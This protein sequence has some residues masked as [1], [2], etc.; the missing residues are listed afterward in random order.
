MAQLTGTAVLILVFRQPVPPTRF[1]LTRANAPAYEEPDYRFDGDPRFII[2]PDA[3]E[4]DSSSLRDCDES[5]DE[6]GDVP[7]GSENDVLRI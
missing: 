2:H 5:S 7:D 4:N 3:D 1:V 6:C